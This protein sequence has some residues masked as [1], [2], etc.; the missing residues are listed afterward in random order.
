MTCEIKNKFHL[1]ER[2]RD[3]DLTN[4]LITDYLL[5]GIVISNSKSMYLILWLVCLSVSWN[6]GF[7]QEEDDDTA[8]RIHDPKYT[9]EIVANGFVDPKRNGFP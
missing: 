8:P 7:A 6:V 2:R 9:A 3:K 1:C 5:K 4:Y